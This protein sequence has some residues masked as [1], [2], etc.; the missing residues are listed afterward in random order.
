[1]YFWTAKPLEAL[2]IVTLSAQRRS[3]LRPFLVPYQSSTLMAL[4]T[5][6]ARY[7]K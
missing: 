2:L 6:L 4:P 1:M 7:W 5:K 3:I